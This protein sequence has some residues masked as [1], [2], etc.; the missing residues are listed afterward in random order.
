MA[1]VVAEWRGERR[2]LPAPLKPEFEALSLAVRRAFG[3]GAQGSLAFSVSLLFF[4]RLAYPSSF[5]LVCSRLAFTVR[6][7]GDAAEV[8]EQWLDEDGDA[9]QMSSDSEVAEALSL[10]RGPDGD[11]ILSIQ[12]CVCALASLPHA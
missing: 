10:A 1:R 5:A 9:I 12:V 6:A 7:V 3:F 4:S 2:A 11:S 8:S